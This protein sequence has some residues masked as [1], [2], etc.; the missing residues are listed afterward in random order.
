M[1]AVRAGGEVPYPQPLDLPAPVPSLASEFPRLVI[2]EL[3][4]DLRGNVVCAIAL[5]PVSEDVAKDF[6]KA[7]HEWKFKPSETSEGPRPAIFNVTFCAPDTIVT[8][9]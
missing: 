7:I 8:P 6:A 4:V 1:N 3:L 5:T 2:L 9:R